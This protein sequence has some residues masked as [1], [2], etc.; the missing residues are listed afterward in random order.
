M[1]GAAPEWHRSSYSGTNNN[2]LEHA[3][4][5]DGSHAIRDSK[6]PWRRIT[7]HFSATAW[8]AFIEGQKSPATTPAIR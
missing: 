8:Q 1:T 4:L 6:D 3:A 5:P 7:I 2:C